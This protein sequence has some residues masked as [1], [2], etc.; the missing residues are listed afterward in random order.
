VS[1]SFSASVNPKLIV[2]DTSVL[3]QIIA[4]DQ[5]GTLRLLRSGYGVQPVIV[6]A[7]EAEISCLLNN[8]SKFR[9]RQE[10]LRKARGNNTLA[11]ADREFLATIRGS[12]VDAWLRQMESEGE[13]LYLVVDRGEAFSHAASIVLGVPIATNDTSAVYRLLKSGES[14]P[15]P[16]IRFWDLVAFGYQVGHLDDAAC[17]RIRQTLRKLGERM[18]RCFVD[19]SYID[20]LPEF[21]PRLACA[22]H[23]FV[24]AGQPQE[25]FDERLVLSPVDEAARS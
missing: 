18:P 1:H 23:Q 16:I 7:V 22:G 5:I 6:Q 2:I 24:G 20:G 17:D 11:V 9:G 19:R 3:V 21:Y 8:Q 12:G 10:Q 4:T 13:R 25:K 15:R 14:I